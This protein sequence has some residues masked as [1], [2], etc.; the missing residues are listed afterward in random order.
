MSLAKTLH[1]FVSLQRTQF[2]GGAYM[3]PFGM[4]AIMGPRS[5]VSEVPVHSNPI[6]KRSHTSQND[7][8][9]TREGGVRNVIIGV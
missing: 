6:A 4:Y 3:P 9:A 8:C 2:A 5:A 7:V 1:N